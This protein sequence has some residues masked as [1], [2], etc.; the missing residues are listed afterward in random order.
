MSKLSLDGVEVCDLKNDKIAVSR[1]QSIQMK[2]DSTL[3]DSI[4]KV[5]ANKVLSVFHLEALGPQYGDFVVFLDQ[6]LQPHLVTT[7]A[8]TFSEKS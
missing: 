3:L 1:T 2:T 6:K 7:L 5:E 8:Y 4:L